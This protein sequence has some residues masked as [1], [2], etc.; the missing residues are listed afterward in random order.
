MESRKELIWG[1]AA[2]E[3]ARARE[4]GEECGCLV[5]RSHRVGILQKSMSLKRNMNGGLW[6]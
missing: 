2:G 3:R 1:P 5:A 6:T 4:R